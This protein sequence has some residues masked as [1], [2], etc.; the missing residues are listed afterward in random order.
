MLTACQSEFG[1]GDN[2]RA[3]AKIIL[4][5]IKKTVV[6]SSTKESNYVVWQRKMGSGSTIE[7]LT[8]PQFSG[9]VAPVFNGPVL[10]QIP[11]GDSRC[12]RSASSLAWATWPS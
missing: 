3:D 7:T 5:G 11:E 9:P 10:A 1:V 2:A 12:K 6:E 8:M 4:V